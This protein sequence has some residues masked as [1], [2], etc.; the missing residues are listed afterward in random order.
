MLP[1]LAIGGAVRALSH[2][3]YDHRPDEQGHEQGGGADD[4]HGRRDGDP[5]VLRVTETALAAHR[6]VFL[7]GAGK[8][9]V[10]VISQLNRPQKASSH[11]SAKGWRRN[12]QLPAYRGSVRARARMVLAVFII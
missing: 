12:R 9:P 6:L 5:V 1:P 3:R 7:C 2:A 10:C 8:A 4:P 11:S